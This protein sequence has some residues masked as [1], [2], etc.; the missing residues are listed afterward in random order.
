V[1]QCSTLAETSIAEVRA[2]LPTAA[3]VKSGMAQGIFRAQDSAVCSSSAVVHIASCLCALLLHFQLPQ[4]A[5]VLPLLLPSTTGALGRASG[6][7]TGQ[8]YL[9]KL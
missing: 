8:R 2:V 5:P 9:L 3:Q 7:S 6:Y 1:Q 4:H